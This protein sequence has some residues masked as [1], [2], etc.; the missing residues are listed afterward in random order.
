[1][2]NHQEALPGG[3]P[4]HAVRWWE[5]GAGKR[6]EHTFAC[7]RPG[8]LGTDHFRTTGK[9]LQERQDPARAGLA[10]LRSLER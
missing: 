6:M 10:Y 1:M 2:R 9:L 3:P 7:S 4:F 8:G 5:V